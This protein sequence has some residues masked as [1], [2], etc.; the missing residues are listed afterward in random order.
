MILGVNRSDV[1]SFLLLMIY[2]IQHKLI[3]ESPKYD[4][5]TYVKIL[6]QF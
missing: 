1:I 3:I 2:L 5:Q 4:V 6:Y